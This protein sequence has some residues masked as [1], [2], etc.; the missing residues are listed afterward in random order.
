M[1]LPNLF[2][3]MATHQASTAKFTTGKI[4]FSRA[5]IADYAMLHCSCSGQLNLESRLPGA[6]RVAPSPTAPAVIR[7]RRKSPALT[8]RPTSLC[9]HVTREELII[10]PQ[11]PLR[12]LRV[13]SRKRPQ[14]IPVTGRTIPSVQIA[15]MQNEPLGERAPRPSGPTAEAIVLHHYLGLSAEQ[16][17]RAMCI[18]I[19]AVR[20]H[21][22]RGV[23]SLRRPP[24]PE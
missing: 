22:A 8:R 7:C 11:G 9:H 16:T 17:A 2:A 24:R 10:Q 6:R 5:N 23:C 13:G 19:G 21:L 1:Y 4:I 12:R 14:D 18:S 15:C 3:D 20:S